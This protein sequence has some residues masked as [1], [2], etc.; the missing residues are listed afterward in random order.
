MTNRHDVPDGYRLG[1]FDAYAH[2]LDRH[3]LIPML[4][5]L[6]TTH[7][8]LITMPIALISM[9]IAL[10]FDLYAYCLDLYCLD[11]YRLDHYAYRRLGPSHLCGM[12]PMSYVCLLT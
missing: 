8:A 3:G 11:L 1:P 5:V 10:C 9:P 7:I 12:T 4:N 2:R 6:I